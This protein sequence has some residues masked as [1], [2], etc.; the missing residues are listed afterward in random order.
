MTNRI[1]VSLPSKKITTVDVSEIEQFNSSFIYNFFKPDERTNETGES[2]PNRYRA[3]N[4]TDL[5]TDISTNNDFNTRVARYVRLTWRPLIIGDRSDIAR[6]VR[7]RDNIDKIYFEDSFSNSNYNVLEIQD[8]SVDTKLNL[9][10]NTLL[11]ATNQSNEV[12]SANDALI[13]STTSTETRVRPELLA[14]GLNPRLYRILFFNA[15]G[16]E[17]NSEE[18]LKILRGYK[19]N[20]QLN[21]KIISDVVSFNSYNDPTNPFG[22]ELL[23]FSREAESIQREA[24]RRSSE[25]I[26]R[27]EY[28]FEIDRYITNRP[29]FSEVHDPFI[30]TIGYIIEKYELIGGSEIRK[31]NIFVED[32]NKNVYIDLKIKYGAIYVYKIRPVFYIEVEGIDEKAGLLSSLGILVTSRTTTSFVSCV[33]N[34][35]PP[36]P[37][38]IAFKFDPIENILKISWGFPVNTQMDIKK[39][40]VFKRTSIFEPYELIKQYNFDD[41]EVRVFS[42]ENPQSYLVEELPSA[43]TLYYDREFTRDSIA[44]YALASID[45]HGLT[46][47]YSTQ[48]KVTYN[49]I[50]NKLKVELFSN[51]GAPKAYPNIFIRQDAFVDSIQD[52]Y[53]SKMHVYFNPEY[54]KVFDKDDNDL[55]LL[56]I[57][58]NDCYQIQLINIDVNEQQL[59]KI[60]LEDRTENIIREPINGAVNRTLLKKNLNTERLKNINADSNS[61]ENG[62]ITR[63]IESIFRNQ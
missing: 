9:F 25:R 17:I 23:N 47:N 6:N 53:H 2:V 55:K 4:T 10:I 19:S 8:L 1:Q 24:R 16:E 45:A 39:F 30:Q 63:Q 43:K 58:Q 51:S 3:V 31:E 7:I 34:T 46:S 44:Y 28:E 56:A 12:R 14:I 22:D 35:P 27:E 13:R 54:L 62:F 48:Y 57:K 40:Q 36:P 29:I 5:P 60:R 41:S 38:D 20:I 18:Y 11:Q 50:Q 61:Q 21:N 52:Q 49:K 37:E 15:N 32:P 33:E 59:L 42:G 26:S